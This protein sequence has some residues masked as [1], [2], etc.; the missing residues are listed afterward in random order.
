M[1][2]GYICLPPRSDTKVYL[3]ALPICRIMHF[4]VQDLGVSN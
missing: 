2:L 1:G 3:G 4:P